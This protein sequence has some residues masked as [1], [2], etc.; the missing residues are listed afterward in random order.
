MVRGC[1]VFLGTVFVIES[2]FD[3]VFGNF[4]HFP[5][6]LVW[7]FVNILLLVTFFGISKY[8][9]VIYGKFSTFVGVSFRNFPGFIADAFAI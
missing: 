5:D 7:H 9:G 3:I 6:L 8:M 4:L 1:A 2:R